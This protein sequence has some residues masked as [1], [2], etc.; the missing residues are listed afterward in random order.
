MDIGMIAAAILTCAVAFMIFLIGILVIKET[1]FD[2]I[3]YKVRVEEL[4]HELD[5]VRQ[6]RFVEHMAETEEMKQST[7][8]SLEELD[9]LR[10]KTL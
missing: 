9:K 1:F 8:K 3:A 10:Q 4:E 5:T 6:Q 7:Q 2:D